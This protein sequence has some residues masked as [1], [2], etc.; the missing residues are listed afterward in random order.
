MELG[1]SD[2]APSKTFA[3]K[4]REAAS[5]SRNRYIALGVLGVLVLIVILY[6]VL[7]KPADGSRSGGGGSGSGSGD[8]SAPA[9][10]SGTTPPAC[11]NGKAIG[12]GGAAFKQAPNKDWGSSPSQC[13]GACKGKAN[14]NAWSWAPGSGSGSKAV[15]ASCDCYLGAPK[16]L[17]KAQSGAWGSYISR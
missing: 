17:L 13:F 12:A 6:F 3:E 14:I 10:G 9:S 8:C 7:K 2:A 11:A 5:S 15:P 4:A 1:G 16:G